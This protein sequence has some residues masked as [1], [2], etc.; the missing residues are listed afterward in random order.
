MSTGEDEMKR[1]AEME[2]KTLVF[3]DPLELVIGL[4][5]S[6]ELLLV[7]EDALFPDLRRNARAV[8][9]ARRSKDLD[10]I[11]NTGKTFERIFISQNLVL[12]ELTVRK[13][14]MLVDQSGLMCFSTESEE[15]LGAFIEIVERNWP[16]A[17]IWIC[18]SNVGKICMT[19]AKGSA[20]WQN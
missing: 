20:E 15:L 6:D 12:T 16:R 4:K 17:D 9:V 8:S 14:A 19:N 13:V 11:A 18:H 5:T 1:S 10:V 3:F 7:G 2:N